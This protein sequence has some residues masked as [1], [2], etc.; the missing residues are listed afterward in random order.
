[1]NNNNDQL[2]PVATTV[3][4]A[5]YKDELQVFENNLMTFIA[6][7]GLP[8]NNVLVPVPER[9]KVFANVGDVLLKLT[10]EHKQQSIYVSKFIAAAASGLF[11]AALNYLWDETIFEL[12]KR[13]VR[14]DLEYFY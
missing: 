12:R 6:Q 7:Q 10:H 1:M 5:T 11:D 4:P 9:V 2:V 8:T 14:Y 3:V 13:I